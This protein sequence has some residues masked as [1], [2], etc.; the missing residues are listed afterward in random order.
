MGTRQ[1]EQLTQALAY[2]EAGSSLSVFGDGADGGREATWEIGSQSDAKTDPFWTGFGVLQAKMR[3]FPETPADNLKWAET[4]LGQELAKWANPDSRR[5]KVPEKLLFVTNVRLSPGT[6]GGKESI[7]GFAAQTASNLGLSTKVRVWD[8]ADLCTRI[9]T[10]KSVRHTYGAWILPG[11]ILAALLDHTNEEE[12]RLSNALTTHAARSFLDDAGLSLRQAGS[13][14]DQPLSLADVFTDVPADPV[15]WDATRH[16]FVR[17][18]ESLDKAAV[19]ASIVRMADDATR[20]SASLVHEPVRRMVLVGGPGQGKSTV[21]QYL[22]QL[23]RAAFLR[24]SEVASSP[25]LHGAMNQLDSNAESRQIAVPAGR[26]WPVRV[27]LSDFADALAR[28]ETPSLLE[29]IAAVVSRKSPVALT[30]ENMLSWLRMHPWLL[31]VDGLDEVP[32]SSNRAEVLQALRDFYLEADNAQSDLV[33][34]ATTRPQGYN[35]EFS[36]ER[37]AHLALRHLDRAQALEYAKVLVEARSG[38]GS[39][40]SERTLTRLQRSSEDESTSRLFSSPLQVAILTVIVEKLGQVPSDRWR[41]FSQYYDVM[42]NREREKGGALADLLLRHESDVNAI[43]RKIA[44]ELQGRNAEVGEASATISREAFELIIAERLR[45]QEHSDEDVDRLAAQFMALTTER[46]VFLAALTSETIGFEIRSLQ[47]FMAG[48]HIVS[49]PEAEVIPTLASVA[50]TP[51]WRNAVL[52]AAGKILIEREP[53]KSELLRLCAELDLESEV[54]QITKPGADLALDILLDGSPNSQ[55]RY[56]KPLAERSATLLNGIPSDRSMELAGVREGEAGKILRRAATDLSVAPAA[57]WMNRIGALASMAASG[58]MDGV[59]G[60][61]RAFSTADGEMLQSLVEHAWRSGDEHLLRA[62]SG[63]LLD[64]NPLRLSYFGPA[65]HNSP[66]VIDPLSS[67]LQTI[68]NRRINEDASADLSDGSALSYRLASSGASEDWETIASVE[69][70]TA[71]WHFLT[72]VAKFAVQ[73][74]TE[75]LAQCLE[76]TIELPSDAYY[77]L[78]SM[79]WV[80]AACTSAAAESGPGDHAGSPES[81]AKL[82][83]EGALGTPEDW[84]T[85]EQRVSSMGEEWLTQPGSDELPVSPSMVRDGLPWRA[86]RGS[87]NMPQSDADSASLLTLAFRLGEA[88]TGSGPASFKALVSGGAMFALAHVWESTFDGPTGLLTP[89]VE[90]SIVELATKICDS[91]HFGDRFLWCDWLSRL[92]STSW[93]VLL[94]NGT[95]SRI[96]RLPQVSPRVSDLYGQSHHEELAAWLSMKAVAPH[97]DPLLAR[98]ATIFAP[99]LDIDLSSLQPPAGMGGA[100]EAKW[101]RLHAFHQIRTASAAAIMAGDH[102]QDVMEVCRSD[103]SDSISANTLLSLA[104]ESR[105]IA[106][107]EVAARAAV[108]LTDRAVHRS[109]E[110]ARIAR[111]DTLADVDYE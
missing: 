3:Q 61:D 40:A 1:F 10:N 106:P 63:R 108:L 19:T 2:A 33:C 98:L 81:L 70:R 92:S 18:S 39:S 109:A 80:V 9:D 88:A 51:Y 32:V 64:V 59:R 58:D 47:E 31:L 55:P 86:F 41:L 38:V 111:E 46:L 50:S 57:T 35:D 79:P 8:Y 43:H 99:A 27:I 78:R 62:A 107:R 25:D 29:Y 21:T 53:L 20:D 12:R 69:P 37:Y 85:I 102:D 77:G 17:A 71:A 74:S 56:S 48:E 93:E 67:A 49:L 13:V 60:L 97:G 4:E 91:E 66:A 84:L 26:R 30:A 15:R 44:F 94:E 76:A 65:R 52:F 73:P 28:Q 14:A 16:Y 95:L 11:D 83:R 36:P 104:Q 23:Y 90:T 54:S 34:I 105:L 96:A 68:M 45:E 101:E 87:L 5:T 110:F 6:G 42:T 82:A 22:A 103:R 89:S 75:L 24:G 100:D 72:K 7:L